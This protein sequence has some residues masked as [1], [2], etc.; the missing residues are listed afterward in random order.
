MELLKQTPS[1][2]FLLTQIARPHNN[3]FKRQNMNT[4]TEQPPAL[5]TEMAEVA[6]HSDDSPSES[7]STRSQSASPVSSA[8]SYTS[9]IGYNQEPWDEY[10]SRV[11]KLCNSLWPVPKSI[12][13]RLSKRLRTKKLLRSILPPSQVPTIER[14]QGGDY[15]R[16]TGLTLPLPKGRGTQKL[17]LRTNRW[18]EG[19]PDRE[20]AILDYVRQKTTIPVPEVVKKD[21]T[22]NNALEKAYVIQKRIPGGDLNSIWESL[23]HSQRCSVARELGC[24]VKTL[25]SLESSVPG[26]IEAVPKPTGFASDFRIVPL[27]VKEPGEEATEEQASELSSQESL[28]LTHQTIGEFF[29]FQ[30]GRWLA[31]A[32]TRPFERVTNLFTRLLEIVCEMNC[33]GLF[34]SATYCLCHVDLHS[35]NIMAQV[36]S[37]GSIKITGIL[38]FDEAVMAPKF[39]NCQPPWWLWHEEGDERVDEEVDWPYELAA[40]PDFPHKAENQEL[41]CLFEEHAGS[42]WRNMAYDEHSRLSRCLFILA[43]EGLE[44]SEHFKAADRIIREWKARHTT[45]V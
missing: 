15:N 11:E 44:S 10:R 9:T 3:I 22:C 40:A 18:G 26:L 42:E 13:A 8:H 7:E 34:N 20:A 5:E 1:N 35:R 43:K 17:I 32:Q 31:M 30:F 4:N 37:D 39:V 25:L 2:C 38:D 16:I 27:E 24:V 33:M 23:S 28:P 19:R 41:K 21:F 45:L 6:D 12:S 36:Q 14:L 29:K